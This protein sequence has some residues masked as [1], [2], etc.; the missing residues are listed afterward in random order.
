MDNNILKLKQIIDKSTNIVVFTGAGIS[1]PSGIPDFRSANGIYNQKSG[2][3]YSPEEIISH[4][5]FWAHPEE[6]YQFYFDKMVY[7]DAKPNKAHLYFAKLGK[8][9]MVKIV[10]QNIDGLDFDAGSKIVYEIHGSIK[11]NHCTKCNKFYALKDLNKKGVP[12]C[13]CGGIIKPDVILYEEGL[14][15]Y[16]IT[17]SIRAIEA[18]DAVIVIGTSLQVYP[19]AS[20]VRYY[21]GSNLVLINKSKTPYDRYANLVI[22]DDIINVI[23]ELEK[24]DEH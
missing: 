14:D 16:M 1:V 8:K 22:N 3:S 13:D 11:R 4:S 21:P 12:Y 2:F 10:T 18:A 20:F 6:F 9:K 23:E 5:F 24:L 19:A 15:E 7:P 17:S